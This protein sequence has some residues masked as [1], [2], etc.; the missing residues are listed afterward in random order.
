[1]GKKIAIFFSGGLDSTYL[2]WKNLNDGNEVYP[3]YVEIENNRN[4]TILEKNRVELLFEEFSK[5]FNKSELKIQSIKHLMNICINSCYDDELK[6]KQLPIW[7][8]GALYLQCR[9][10]DEIQIAYVSNDDAISYLSEIQAIYNSYS[11]IIDNIKPLT[12]PLV[13][14]KKEEIANELPKQYLDLIISCEMP[15]II[16]SIDAKIIEYE[17]C[18]ECVP[19]KHIISSNYYGL[20]KYPNRYNKNLIKQNAYVLL[21]NGY[22]IYNINGIEYLNSSDEPKLSPIQLEFNFNN[23]NNEELIHN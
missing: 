10:F 18:C 22:K 21:C 5:E 17:P 2:V 3:F 12:F 8:L 4:K 20:N 15:K 23:D 9:N 13:K 7:I 19:C 1:M 6:F 14:I 11:S 16:G